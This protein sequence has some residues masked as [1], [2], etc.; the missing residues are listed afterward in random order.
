[1]TIILLILQLFSFLGSQIDNTRL[2]WSPTRQHA[3][4]ETV[5][6]TYLWS[7]ENMIHLMEHGYD[8]SL[9]WSDIAWDYDQQRVYVLPQSAYFT[10]DALL[11]YDL[12]TGEQVATFDNSSSGSTRQRFVLADN[13][14]KIVVYITS[15]FGTAT[16][17][18]RDTMTQV[19]VDLGDGA[20][21]GDYV[22]L[23][24]D[25]RYLVISSIQTVRVWDLEA[26]NRSPIITQSM[27]RIHT[28][29]FVDMTIL[30]FNDGAAQIDCSTGLIYFNA[31][32][33]VQRIGLIHVIDMFSDISFQGGN[34]PRIHRIV[35]LPC[36]G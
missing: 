7:D 6:G 14:N 17:W 5:S 23:S 32:L 2:N 18:D 9:S 30:Q 4:V 25:G 28:L 10:L 16:I 12:N 11:A 34:P 21:Y 29:Q 8:P 20:N 13:G 3:I 19:Q 15:G 33:V 36:T 35:H 26:E 31:E 27:D 24:P 22:A 1:M